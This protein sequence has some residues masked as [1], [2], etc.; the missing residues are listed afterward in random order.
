MQEKRIILKDSTHRHLS[1]FKAV[2]QHKS[3]D[4]AITDLLVKNQAE[5]T[6]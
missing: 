6:Q 2:A 5:R 4:D 3:F 1:V